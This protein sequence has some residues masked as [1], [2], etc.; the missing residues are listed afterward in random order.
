M[1][2]RSAAEDARQRG[3]TVD[4]VWAERSAMYGPG[5]VVTPEEVAETLAFLCSDEA[6]GVNGEAVTVALGSIW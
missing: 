2:D 1:A 4:E 6:S 5:R 3:I